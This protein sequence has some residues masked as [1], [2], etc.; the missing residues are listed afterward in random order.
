VGC[1]ELSGLDPQTCTELG[2]V[3]LERRPGRTSDDEITVYK[4]MGHVIEDIVAAEL[5]YRCA[6]EQGSGQTVE[7]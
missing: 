3:V 1:A 6:R 4:A 5:A 2:E 7:L